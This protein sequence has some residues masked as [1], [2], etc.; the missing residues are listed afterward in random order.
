MTETGE[1]KL[2]HVF[3]FL[4]YY[5]QGGAADYAGSV[6]AASLDEV[7]QAMV[8]ALLANPNLGNPDLYNI[9]DAGMKIVETG[10]FDVDYGPEGCTVKVVASSNN[11]PEQ[12]YLGLFNQTPPA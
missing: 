10:R 6:T 3:W 5:P 2:Y 11:P 9:A 4:Q 7:R 1:R 12:Y 8:Q